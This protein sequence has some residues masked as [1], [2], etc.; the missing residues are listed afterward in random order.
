MDAV[1]VNDWTDGY[2]PSVFERGISPDVDP[3][4]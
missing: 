2:T 4:L 1:L 3:A